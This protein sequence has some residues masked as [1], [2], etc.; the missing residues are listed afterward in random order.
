MV[1]TSLLMSTR[2]MYFRL[3]QTLHF[4]SGIETILGMGLFLAEVYIWGDAAAE[5]PA[6]DLA[7]EAR[8]RPA[9][10]R[11]EHL[12]DGRYLY[13][14]YNEPL[15]VVRDTVLAAQCIDYPADKNENL[16]AG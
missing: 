7:A 3:T 14:S 8:N 5:L 4:N 2:Y 9:T 11:Y 15:E 10:G 13:P 1:V 12:A 16:S 6:N